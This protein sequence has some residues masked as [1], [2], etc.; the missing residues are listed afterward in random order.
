M[1]KKKQQQQQENAYEAQLTKHWFIIEPF[2]S[3]TSLG[4]LDKKVTHKF[5]IQINFSYKKIQRNRCKFL[6]SNLPCSLMEYDCF[7]FLITSF[8]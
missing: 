7:P 5:I 8:L 6:P 3:N 1:Q 4:R 2:Q